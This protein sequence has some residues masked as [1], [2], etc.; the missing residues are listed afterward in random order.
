MLNVLF[1]NFNINIKIVFDILKDDDEII[2]VCDKLIILL[3]EVEYNVKIMKF[4]F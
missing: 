4:Y 2:L 3:K 1:F